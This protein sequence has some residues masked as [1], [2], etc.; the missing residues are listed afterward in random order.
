MS[1]VIFHNMFASS[2][3]GLLDQTTFAPRPN[4]WAASLW[5]KLMGTTVLDSG[6]PIREGLHVYAHRLRG[7]PG[8][9]ALLVINKQS[10]T[11]GVD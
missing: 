4:Y 6:V 9:V 1:N 7:H 2:E 5:R 10:N 11:E 8:G 3:Y